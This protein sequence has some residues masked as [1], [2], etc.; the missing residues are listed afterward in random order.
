MIMKKHHVTLSLTVIAA[1]LGACSSMPKTTPL[2]DQTRAEYNV[3]Q[4]NSKVATYAPLEMKLASEALE[5]AN[6][7]ARHND[8]S[9]QIDKLAYL[10]K[11]K[12]ALT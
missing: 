2:L 12:I 1:L 6:A 7:A 3:A 8:S 5:Q 4:D 9:E 10:A 11:Q